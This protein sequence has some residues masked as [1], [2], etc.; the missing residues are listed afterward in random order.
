[1]QLGFQYLLAIE[2]V[3]I[4]QLKRVFR[5]KGSPSDS[6]R[7]ASKQQQPSYEAMRRFSIP[8]L[9]FTEFVLLPGETGKKAFK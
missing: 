7:V 5:I 8:I 2:T 1:V 6:C 9:C 3:R 4:Q